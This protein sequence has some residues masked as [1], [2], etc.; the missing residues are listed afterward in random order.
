MIENLLSGN[1]VF[2]ID[3]FNTTDQSAQR[4]SNYAKGHQ[5]I[6]SSESFIADYKSLCRAK[7]MEDFMNSLHLAEEE[8]GEDLRGVHKK[9][10]KERLKGVMHESNQ[11]LSAY[12]ASLK[13]IRNTHR[14]RQQDF[15]I[16]SR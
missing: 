14:I 10:N 11:L 15:V 9:R 3:E 4:R 16:V 8:A 12:V 13:T 6:L 7:S 2:V 5:L 1:A